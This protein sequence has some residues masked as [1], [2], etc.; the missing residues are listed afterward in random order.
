LRGSPWEILGQLFRARDRQGSWHAAAN[1]LGVGLAELGMRWARGEITVIQEHI[2]TENL[3]RALERAVEAIP[4]TAHDPRCVLATAEDDEHT[5]GLSLVELCLREAGWGTVWSGSRTPTKD[6]AD[7]A[8]SG[9]VDMLAMSASPASSDAKQLAR[10][11]EQLGAACREA[12]VI[13]AFGGSGPWPDAPDY[14]T[15]V[16]DLLTLHRL[17]TDWRASIARRGS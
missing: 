6:L 5:L 10:E 7:L 4:S 12:G 2:A 1:E 13:L 11:A 8:R 14:G 17:A 9:D 15:R 16:R 3:S